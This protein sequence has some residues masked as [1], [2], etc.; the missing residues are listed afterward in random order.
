MKKT[1]TC[2][3]IAMLMLFT[4][5]MTTGL[6]EKFVQSETWLNGTQWTCDDMAMKI[7]PKDGAYRVH[8]LLANHSSCTYSW[9]YDC[10]YD[11]STCILTSTKGR[12]AIVN[13]FD[14]RL[15]NVRRLYDDGKA[16]FTWSENGTVEWKDF[17]TN[18]VSHRVFLLT[19]SSGN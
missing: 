3:L 8:V 18:P 11:D 4:V 7:S 14:G 2:L 5:S 10:S 13:T 16:T 1:I 17:K 12:M 6:A 15:A 19:G 9:T